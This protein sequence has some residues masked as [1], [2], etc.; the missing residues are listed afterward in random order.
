MNSMNLPLFPPITKSFTLEVSNTVAV[1]IF[2]TAQLGGF[3]EYIERQKKPVSHTYTNIHQAALHISTSSLNQ[4]SNH[5]S[6]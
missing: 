6:T 1:H 2:Y 4:K 5:P 3:G